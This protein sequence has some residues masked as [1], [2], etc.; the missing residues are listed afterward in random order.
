M[1]GGSIALGT[2]TV[3]WS[4]AEPYVLVKYSPRVENRVLDL[5]IRVSVTIAQQGAS[6]SVSVIAVAVDYSFSPPLPTQEPLATLAKQK[7]LSEFIQVQTRIVGKPIIPS[8][9]IPQSATGPRAIAILVV[10]GLSV[11]LS[12]SGSNV[13]SRDARSNTYQLSYIT[14][15]SAVTTAIKKEVDDGTEGGDEDEWMLT[16]AGA[17]QVLD[18]PQ[19]L[20]LSIHYHGHRF[21]GGDAGCNILWCWDYREWIDA[22]DDVAVN[23]VFSALT[24]G[25]DLQV[26]GQL[27]QF[28][29]DVPE[30]AIST[31]G[32]ISG[33]LRPLIVPYIR[34]Q[35]QAQVNAM[36]SGFDSN[37]IGIPVPFLK[38]GRR[39]LPQVPVLRPD[40]SLGTLEIDADFT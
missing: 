25:S 21:L 8:E 31:H 14:D 12:Q 34:A 24:Q 2:P 23:V 22:E 15:L 9:N 39:T 3:D 27:Y 17:F 1:N 11:L 13:L 40:G 29:Y 33:A 20:A 5:E 36:A 4:G 19:R 26:K 35:I 30:S 6:T 32:N 18:N 38:P 10:D 37:P 7:W 16:R 28:S